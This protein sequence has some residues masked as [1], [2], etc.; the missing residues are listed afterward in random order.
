MGSLLADIDGVAK[1]GLCYGPT[2]SLLLRLPGRW[3]LGTTMTRPSNSM[4]QPSRYITKRGAKTKIPLIVN[5]SYILHG[6]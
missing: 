5:I 2:R 1:E 3:Y 4:A 6:K